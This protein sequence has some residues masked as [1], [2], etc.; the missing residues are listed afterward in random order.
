[1]RFIVI[2]LFLIS[3]SLFF[4]VYVSPE[5][6]P[7]SG[8][9]PL[10]IPLF[11]LLN[12]FL[13]VMFLFGR[14][15]LII[16]PII[17]LALGYKFF[18]ITFQWNPREETEESITLLS[19]NTMQ[20]SYG[21]YKENLEKSK[22]IIQWAKDHPADIKCFQEF[23]QDF[24]TPSKNAIKIITED[25]KLNHSYQSIIGNRKNRS[26]GVAIVSRFPIINE[27]RVFDNRRNN[28]AMFVDLVVKKD[29]MRIY[30]VHLESM[31][32]PAEE[33]SDV[34]GI[35]LHYRETI[36]KIKN[37]TIMR[38]EQLKT[39]KEHMENSPYPVIIAGDFN[40]I[41]YSYT[42]F[43]LRSIL[44]NAFEEAGKGFGFTYNKV[45][46]FLRIDHIF[47]D[48]VF[49]AKNF[50]THTEVDYSDHYPISTEFIWKSP[51]RVISEEN[52][53]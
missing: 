3:L 7:Y 13:A 24:T 35:K 17:A 53:P 4:S 30:N 39:L 43:S 52:A 31:S 48:K 6:F 9:L 11:M 41:P 5:S 40:D 18:G 32:I 19:F 51:L 14:S 37:G 8:L 33:L 50:R 10:L 36:R 47:H 28:G 49:K 44:N 42:Y 23:Y 20:F 21:M 38:A 29:T 45:L 15:R 25:G 27:G 16:Y 22:N 46:F 12:I 26:H 1:M 2:I 34:E